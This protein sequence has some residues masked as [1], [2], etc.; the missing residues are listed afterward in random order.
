MRAILFCIATM[1][2]ILC[3]VLNLVF[4]HNSSEYCNE[5]EKTLY[6]NC[7]NTYRKSCQPLNINYFE[8]NLK[9]FNLF[10]DG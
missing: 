8:I 10:D 2:P 1:I 4:D 5:A 6:D 7:I 9:L 3:T